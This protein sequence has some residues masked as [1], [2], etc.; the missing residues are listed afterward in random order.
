MEACILG[1]ESV[2]RSRFTVD[3]GGLTANHPWFTVEAPH[4]LGEA[5]T[6]ER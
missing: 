6:M 5:P 4:L 1:D 3:P 2:H